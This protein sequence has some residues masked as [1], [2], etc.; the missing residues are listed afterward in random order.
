MRLDNNKY[1]VLM[2]GSEIKW[3]NVFM[4]IFCVFDIRYVA[5]LM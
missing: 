2:I 1:F 4:Y 5:V 3:I